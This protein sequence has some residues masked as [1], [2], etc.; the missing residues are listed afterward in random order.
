MGTARA[1]SVELVGSGGAP[2]E[3]AFARAPSLPSDQ[4]REFKGMPLGL[5]EDDDQLHVPEPIQPAV[6]ALDDAHQSWHDAE[7]SYHDANA[8]R[9]HLEALVQT[10]RNVTFRLQSRKKDIPDFDDWYPAW[11]SLMKADPH[12]KW[13][14]DTRTELVHRSGMEQRSRAR[15]SLIRSYLLEPEMVGVVPARTDTEKLIRQLITQIPE[16]ERRDATVEVSRLWESPLLP[17]VDLLFVTVRAFHFLDALLTFAGAHVEG[18]DL[19]DEDAETVL[20]MTPVP[21]CMAL[22]PSLFPLLVAADTMDQ[23]DVQWHSPEEIETGDGVTLTN[24]LGLN[25]AALPDDFGD[26][27]RAHHELARTAM[28]RLKAHPSLLAI[29][30]GSGAWTY[31]TREPADRREKYVAWY[32]LAKEARF[33]DIDAIIFTAEVWQAPLESVEQ[34]D[35]LPASLGTVRGATEWLVTWGE[36]ADGT[37][38]S[39]SSEIVRASGLVLLK[40]AREDANYESGGFLAPLRRVWDSQSGSELGCDDPT[41]E[42]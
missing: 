42:A 7:R 26:R 33:S 27:V 40:S 20:A 8:F 30:D 1:V 28:K 34:L 21:S 36:V 24:A 19:R 5:F 25:A 13:V 6:D 29:R 11:Q 9:R 37:S 23:L 16:S 14:D 4:R 10:L 3:T 39:L 35:L 2:T 22:P 18:N 17:G 32:L 12:L 15:L 38:K 41:D 31:R